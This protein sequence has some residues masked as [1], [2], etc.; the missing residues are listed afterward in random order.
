[1]EKRSLDFSKLL[2]LF[3]KLCLCHNAAPAAVFSDFHDGKALLSQMLYYLQFFSTKI[4]EEI[5]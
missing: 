2:H 3:L 4:P 5:K 1:M